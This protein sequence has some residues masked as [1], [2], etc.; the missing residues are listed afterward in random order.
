MHFLKVKVPMGLENGI[1]FPSLGNLIIFKYGFVTCISMWLG[2]SKSCSYQLWQIATILV[3]STRYGGWWVVGGGG[4]PK[5]KAM[6]KYYNIHG[7]KYLDIG[8]IRVC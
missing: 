5:T 3:I 2:P 8:K 6:G 4:T 7:T 1:A